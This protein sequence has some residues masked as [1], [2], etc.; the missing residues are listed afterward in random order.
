MLWQL[1]YV[2]IPNFYN[3][4][5]F[6]PIDGQQTCNVLLNNFI[7]IIPLSNKNLLP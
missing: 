4:I 6:M 7:V 3:K 1:Q 5:N 2:L